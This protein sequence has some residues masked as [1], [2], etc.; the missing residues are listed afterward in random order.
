MKIAYVHFYVEDATASRNWFVA[1]LGFQ[2]VASSINI[3]TCTEV[4]KNGPVY[5]VLSSPLTLLSPV[6]QFLSQHPPGVADIAF[7]VEDLEAVMTRALAHGAK[8]L[9]PI[10]QQ[11]QDDLKWGKIAAWGSLAHSLIE[12]QEVSS[13]WRVASSEWQV[14]PASSSANTFTGIDHLV[15]NVATGDLES[16][17]AWYQKT[18]NFR[19]LQTFK[20]QTERSAL[21]SKVMVSFNN[22]V[23]LPVNQPASPNSQIQEFLDVNRGPG[24]QHIA[25]QTPNII[26]AIAD[27]R[28]RG[29]SF[30]PVPNTYYTQLQERQVPLSAAELAEITTQQ[31]LVDWQETNSHA[32]LLQTFTQP[33]FGQPTFFFELIERRAQAPGFGEG[34]F[35]ALFEAIEREQIKRGSLQD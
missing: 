4:V 33:I 21:D 1:Q 3:H 6:A 9:Q 22:E 13:Q 7:V 12:Q 19:S 32:L 10:Q 28:L 15:L 5:F 27:F 24:I 25:L 30:L 18:L 16:A 31:I 29:V 2:A 17:V 26:E 23:Q 35:R 8:V 34:N 14:H 11:H 20:I